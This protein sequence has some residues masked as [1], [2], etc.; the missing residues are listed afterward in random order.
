MVRKVLIG[1][2][3]LVALFAAPASA[4]YPDF[5]V[6][7]GSVEVGGNATFQGRGCQPGETVT[8]T[9]DGR[10]MATVEAD[11]A[12]E[13][14]GS[15]RA[16]LAPGNYTVVATC[17]DVVN[18]SPLQVRGASTTPPPSTGGGALPRTGSDSNTLALV[19][20]GLLLAGGG[21]MLVARKR[22]A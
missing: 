2:L 11:G 8:I 21:A 3:M 22:F 1:A 7:P 17:G 15:F 16:D 18:T 6:N 20:A 10:V 13:F 12:G 4:Q 5:T 9:I 14:S 19:G